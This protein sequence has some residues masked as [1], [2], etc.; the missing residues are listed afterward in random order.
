[1]RRGFGK[2]IAISVSS[3]IFVLVAAFCWIVYTDQGTGWAIRSTLKFLPLKTDF[4]KITGTL[5]RGVAME[6]VHIEFEKWKVDIESFQLLWQPGTILYGRGIIDV[7]ALQGVSLEDKYPHDKSPT[8]LT[9]PKVPRFLSFINGQVRTFSVKEVTYRSEGRQERVLDELRGNVIWFLG[10]LVLKDLF[11]HM[12]SLTAVGSLKTGFSVPAFSADIAVQPKKIAGGIDTIL[13][14]TAMKKKKG[15]LQIQGE[16]SLIAVSGK[17]HLAEGSGRM[18]L[19]HSTIEL[20]DFTIVKK[21]HK[22]RVTATGMLDLSSTNPFVNLHINTADVDLSKEFGINTSIS[23]EIV[24][25]SDFA[26]YDGRFDL[27][28]SGTSW[29]DAALSGNIKGDYR[30]ISLSELQGRLLGGT[31]LGSI[32]GSLDRRLSLSGSLHV[33]NMNP[34]LIAPR[35]EG[36]VNMN[37]DGS[38]TL[39][40]GASPEWALK[41][42]VL[43]SVLRDRPFTGQANV[44]WAEGV[45]RHSDAEFSGHGFHLSASGNITEKLLY[46]VRLADLGDFVPNSHGQILAEG[47]I[48]RDKKRL[49]VVLRGDAKMLSLSSAN[50]DA[51][52]VAAQFNTDGNNIIKGT[53]RAKTITYGGL[54]ADS[55]SLTADGTLARHE[56]TIAVNG[57]KERITT[58]FNGGY[59]KKMWQGMCTQMY[60]TDHLLGPFV[61][62]RPVPLKVSRERFTIDPFVLTGAGREELLF[63]AD[64][65]LT[66]KNGYVKG[67]WQNLHIARFQRLFTAAPYTG[68]M[69]GSVTVEWPVDQTLY[70]TAETAFSDVALGGTSL[71]RIPKGDAKLKWD[72]SGL[73]ASWETMLG[74]KGKL[75]GDAW[76]KETTSFSIPKNTHFRAVWKDV[77]AAMFK[78]SLPA[79]LNLKGSLS[80][81]VNGLLLPEARFEIE[82]TAKLHEGYLAW[83]NTKGE[84]G[85]KSE[86]VDLDFSWKEGTAKGALSLTLSNRTRLK[87]ECKIP[88]F[89]QLPVAINPNGPVRATATGEMIEKG[90]LTALFP[91]LIEQSESNLSFDLLMEG[92][93]SKPV[94]QGKALLT[95]ASAYLYTAGLSLKDI[96]AEAILR[97]DHIDITSF[98]LR[99]G[100]GM[101]NGSAVVQIKDWRLARY[102]GKLRCPSATGQ[103]EE[104]RLCKS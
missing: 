75:K 71:L 52:H 84:T 39:P 37:I 76:S 28:N 13:L 20:T 4:R 86:N 31:L 51:V 64:L 77:D 95:G 12:P 41:T 34:G 40:Q 103:N 33:R 42:R 94:F 17:N 24:L 29:K 79:A 26:K 101:L 70:I 54:D 63:E 21:D 56:L 92:T 80:G 99:S 82:G 48:K 59:A 72:K 38:L 104:C 97:K 66:P 9:W 55:M 23:G 102:E 15:P 67:R 44:Q 49:A 74:D 85:I 27:R 65:G 3:V 90:L 25:T 5:A 46:T 58:V 7:V 19:G 35:W 83:K 57:K 88:L 78:P 16:I 61:L 87:A 22:G 43:N 10:D 6:A 89:A 2:G 47:W 98:A 69:S 45:F 11:I 8:D 68:K 32:K 100:P 73:S 30:A 36:S 93:W 81:E 53:M 14:K 91:G 1:M 96:K 60:V 18:G 62:T 50:M